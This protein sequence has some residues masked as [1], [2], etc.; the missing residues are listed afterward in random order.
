MTSSIA[1]AVSCMLAHEQLVL[2]QVGS[3]VRCKQNPGNDSRR[4]VDVE[5]LPQLTDADR[6]ILLMQRR[7]RLQDMVTRTI[8]PVV[9]QAMSHHVSWPCRVISA[10]LHGQCCSCNF[11][12]LNVQ[13]L[14]PDS[15]IMRSRDACFDGRQIAAAVSF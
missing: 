1:S 6:E 5:D 15:H 8:G 14:V 2:S 13:M 9:K 4:Q 7:H 12:H 11:L 10:V 3:M